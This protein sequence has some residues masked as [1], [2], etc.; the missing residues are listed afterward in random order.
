MSKS[1][2]VSASS[3]DELQEAIRL[4]ENHEFSAA[5]PILLK[6][7]KSGEPKACLQLGYAYKCGGDGLEKDDNLSESWYSSYIFNLTVRWNKGDIAA[8]RELA[9]CYQYGDVVG[10]DEGKAFRLYSECAK[11]GDGQSQFHLSS[12]WRHGLCGLS[13]NGEAALYWLDMAVQ[14]EYP[15]ALYQ[16]GLDLTEG[17]DLES[18]KSG[19]V[20]I[21]KAASLGFWP[22]QK[23]LRID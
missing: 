13:K 15:E 18:C 14:A 11:S 19:R 10:I 16:K 8:A 23:Y 7:G 1:L 6:Y 22:A 20:L 5:L 12:L 17:R 9:G 2:Q 4:C 3:D 21:E